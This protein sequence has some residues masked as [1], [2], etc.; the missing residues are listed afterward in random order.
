M[1]SII[2][3]DLFIVFVCEFKFAV[4]SMGMSHLFNKGMLDWVADQFVLFYNKS[5]APVFLHFP[6]FLL[7]G[8]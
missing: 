5:K 1:Y 6:L 2:V 8:P 4:C 7:V 3:T